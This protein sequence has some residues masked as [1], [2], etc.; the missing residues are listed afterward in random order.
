MADKRALVR[1]SGR[2][3]PTLWQKV[4][5]GA[6]KMVS[7]V[8]FVGPNSGMM[9]RL[10]DVPDPDIDK[11]TKATALVTSAYC[12]TAV[13]Y[14]M[15][16]VA[17]PPL[18]VMQKEEQ[19]D[20]LVLDH[21]LL[22]VLDEPSPDFDFSELMR[23]TEAYT[24]ISG[25][26]AWLK[27]RDSAGRLVALQ[28][29]SGDQVRTFAADGRI[30]GRFKLHT[31]NGWQ[32]YAPEDVVWI[33]E[34]NPKSWRHNLARLDVALAQL[35][36]GHQVNRTVSKFM[37]KAMFP[38][39]VVSPHPDWNP[40]D[41][42]WA[43]YV[44]EIE[45]WHSGPA[46]AG[47]PLVL[48]GGTVFSRAAIPLK[49]LLPSELLDRIEATVSSVFGIPPIVLGWKVGLENSPWSQMAE[50]RRTVYEETLVPR[51]HDYERKVGRQLLDREE[52]AAGLKLG[53]DLEDIAALRVD[54][55]ARAKV[56][57]LMVN[58]WTRNERR[59]YTGQEPLPDSDPRGN[60]IGLVSNISLSGS[61][62]DATEDEQLSALAVFMG[63]T[64]PDTVKAATARYL[65]MDVKLVDRKA[66]EWALFDINTKAAE[67]T[68]ESATARMLGEMKAE[69]LSLA[70]EYI[71]EE[72]AADGDSII[73]FMTA[74][75]SWLRGNGEKLMK[76]VLQP[77]VTSSAEAGVKR[78]AAQVGVS[79]AT[80][81][82]GLLTYAQEET[83]FLVSV[84]GETTGKRVAEA[85][86]AGLTEGETIQALRK[87]LEEL[88][89][90]N[91]ERAK[92]VAR[93]ET[94]RAWNGAQRR[95]LADWEKDQDE[96]TL[97]FKEWL[98]SMDP[99]VR[100]EH[101]A[102]RGE[103][104]RVDEPYSN[105]LQ[106]PSEPNCRCTQLFSIETV[107]A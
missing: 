42:E 41:D 82:P 23:L 96:G 63:G 89:A 20:E 38:G 98:D 73:S 64:N 105:G 5:Q 25:A 46:N 91:R 58:D 76:R 65:G 1:V 33:R 59:A 66:L 10:D 13:D 69:V 39:G 87:R 44:N 99:R 11:L 3:K 19:G 34:T 32:D 45:S 7:G 106:E 2:K 28:P 43:A 94:T 84:M 50:A 83:D 52:R 4:V 21:E 9:I 15:R 27:V 57:N 75:T 31:A 78:L 70:A 80:L 55:E 67:S 93:T 74:L 26:A 37:R 40:D 47:A 60:E 101:R 86:Q 103:K 6:Q 49:E 88:P 92:L 51:W 56:A 68:W 29:Y 61:T 107:T 97:T 100:P 53:F 81:Q 16:K 8:T 77:L 72:K 104:R 85:V 30:Y 17:E 95:A 14:R 102:L 18:V 79:F 35:D 12:F 48:A 22:M 24:L 54:D 36:L 90:F 62:G 71:R